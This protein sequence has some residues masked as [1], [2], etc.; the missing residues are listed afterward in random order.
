MNAQEVKQKDLEEVPFAVADRIPTFPG[1]EDLSD[2]EL[3]NCTVN[4]INQ[5]VLKNFNTAL[6]KK[7]GIIGETKI[8]VQF[9]INNEGAI[10]DVRSRSMA[11]EK[12]ARI[13]LQNE[14]ERVIKS[15]PKMIP[16]E[17]DGKTVDILYSL[18]I[19]LAVPK[20]GETE[21][22]GK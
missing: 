2:E 12:E 3:K 8:I 21:K 11:K 22:N 19:L 6:G 4:K 9:K 10:T 5:Y 16:G 18:P 7:N 15:F 17:Y 14:A 13:A 1:C 20:Q